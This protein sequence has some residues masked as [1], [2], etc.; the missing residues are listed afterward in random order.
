[1]R[2]ESDGGILDTPYDTGA[3]D[4]DIA[5]TALLPYFHNSE[6]RSNGSSD[7]LSSLSSRMHPDARIPLVTAPKSSVADL[8][9]CY[10]VF[11]GPHH[12]TCVP[13]HLSAA[14]IVPRP[15]PSGQQRQCRWPL[16]PPSP[17]PPTSFHFFLT[18]RAAVLPE[19]TY[20]PEDEDIFFNVS[21][22]SD[23]GSVD[24][25]CGSC[26]NGAADLLDIAATGAKCVCF[27]LC[28]NCCH[29]SRNQKA[30]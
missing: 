7:H 11:V 20:A 30:K 16:L 4:A 25:G 10:V 15:V 29:A 9:P 23:S 6:S 26:D 5:D 18:S 22:G 1:M 17:P 28:D 21:D 12:L 27:G 2:A 13:F 3:D 19:F 24:P 8:C 14:C